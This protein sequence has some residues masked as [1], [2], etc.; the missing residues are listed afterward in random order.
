MKAKIIMLMMIVFLSIFVNAEITTL[1]SIQQG[2][3]GQIVQ[4]FYNSTFQNISAVQIPDKTFI[5]P[6][7]PGMQNNGGGL[8]NRTFCNTS[9]IGDYIVNGYGDKNG[10]IESWSYD[11]KV[12]PS[13]NSGT[14]NLVFFIFIITVIYSINLIGFFGRSEIMTML[15]GMALMFLGVYM[16][17][18]GV[19]IYRDNLTNYLAYLTIGWGFVS[20]MIAAYSLYQEL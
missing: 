2:T 19:I 20:T 16:I 1:P 5:F 10:V 6:A 4:T 11:F 3:C 17:N 15:S 13:G 12:T 18:N 8:F 9:Q 7:N 14:D